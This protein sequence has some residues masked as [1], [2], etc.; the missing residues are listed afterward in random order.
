MFVISVKCKLGKVPEDRVVTK[1][2]EVVLNVTA[3]LFFIF[4]KNMNG[5]Y[6]SCLHGT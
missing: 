2:A 6:F 3:D 5:F 4:I 1:D